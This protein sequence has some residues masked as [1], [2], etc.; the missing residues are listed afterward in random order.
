MLQLYKL[1]LKVVQKLLSLKK[2]ATQRSKKLQVLKYLKMLR[3]LARVEIID[4]KK[5]MMMEFMTI[6]EMMK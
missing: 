2:L 4:T 3:K 1:D 6:A 5:T